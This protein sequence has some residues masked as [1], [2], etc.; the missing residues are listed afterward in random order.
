MTG[1][2]R[3]GFDVRVRANVDASIR[4]Y[5]VAFRE[6]VNNRFDCQSALVKAFQ[7]AW[8]RQNGMEDA[9]LAEEARPTVMY[10]AL[11]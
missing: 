8:E 5:R 9:W 6:S 4:E 3:L 7:E 11:T 10:Y 2:D 1:L